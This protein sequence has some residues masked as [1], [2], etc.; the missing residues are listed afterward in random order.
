MAA[1]LSCLPGQD[2]AAEGGNCADVT[3]LSTCATDELQ[4]AIETCVR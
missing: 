4:T 3:A 2:N 1:E